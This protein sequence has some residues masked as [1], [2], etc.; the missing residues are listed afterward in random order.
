MAARVH[1][2]HKLSL[3]SKYIRS[4]KINHLG[5]RH[6]TRPCSHYHIGI[7]FH[8]LDRRGTLNVLRCAC[9]APLSTIQQVPP[10]LKA[11]G[12]E[13]YSSLA[14]IQ[15]PGCSIWVAFSHK[16]LQS[17]CPV[18]CAGVV[19]IPLIFVDLSLSLSVS[20]RSML[21]PVAPNAV[22]TCRPISFQLPSVQLA[23]L[24]NQAWP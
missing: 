18:S 20:S 2:R 21:S 5:V 4:K 13:P 12:R 7:F 9:V 10:P 1:C 19:V 16:T 22:P 3:S 14:A 6:S 15:P 23:S 11:L 8:R 24:W 17:L